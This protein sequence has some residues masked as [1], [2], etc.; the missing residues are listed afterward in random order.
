[1]LQIMPAIVFHSKRLSTSL[2]LISAIIFLKKLIQMH[3]FSPPLWQ[4]NDGDESVS[5]DNLT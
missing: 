4:K 3:S 5:G 1:M 2:D